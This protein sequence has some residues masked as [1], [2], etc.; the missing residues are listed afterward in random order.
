[1]TDDE[2]TDALAWKLRDAGLVGMSHLVRKALAEVQ[3]TVVHQAQ[4]AALREEAAGWEA[5]PAQRLYDRAD[6]LHPRP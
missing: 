4:A 5:V 1:M 3:L 6:Q 2:I